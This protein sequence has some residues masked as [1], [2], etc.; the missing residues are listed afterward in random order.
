[1]TFIRCCMRTKWNF[2]CL[3]LFVASIRPFKIS[4]VRKTRYQNACNWD[5]FWWLFHYT[6]LIAMGTQIISISWIEMKLVHKI[7]VRVS[8]LEIKLTLSITKYSQSQQFWNTLITV[9]EI[10]YP[11]YDLWNK[12]ADIVILSFNNE[13]VLL[14]HWW[15]WQAAVEGSLWGDERAPDIPPAKPCAQPTEAARQFEVELIYNRQH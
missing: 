14:V 2:L 15:Q 1:M 8:G 9:S 4:K 3:W 12:K 5:R 10:P 13:W 7:T 11:Y 6:R